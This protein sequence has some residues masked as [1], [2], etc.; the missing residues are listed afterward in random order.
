[1]AIYIKIETILD[2]ISF[3][4]WQANLKSFSTELEGVMR[5]L[6]PCVT[7]YSRVDLMANRIGT[8]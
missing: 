7:P 6:E 8:L 3:V 5:G 4:S 2:D 1:M